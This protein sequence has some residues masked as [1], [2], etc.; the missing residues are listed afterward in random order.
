MARGDQIYV[1]RPLINMEGAYEHHGID[2]GDGTVIHY[3]K[4]GE[5][6]TITRTSVETFARGNPIYRKTQPVAYLPDIVVQ[7]AESRLGEQQYQLLTNNCEHFATWCK[8]GKSESPQLLTDGLGYGTLNPFDTRQMLDRAA[9]AGNPVETVKL[10]TQALNQ[11]ATARQ[12]LQTQAN[13]AQT[14]MASWHRVAQAALQKNR[15]DLARA[16]LER[17]VNSKRKWSQIQKQIEDID[18]MQASLL[19]NTKKLQQQIAIDPNH[20]QTMF[21]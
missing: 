19:Q 7:R 13:Q 9:M 16:A 21:R 14:E 11:A 17:K 5:V 3:Y 12:Q 18:A 1:M 6:P 2:C 15:E 20:L 10:L 4:G 8:T